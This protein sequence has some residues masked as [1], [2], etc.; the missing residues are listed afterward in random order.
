MIIDYL[1]LEYGL[2]VLN[3]YHETYGLGKSGVGAG[4]YSNGAVSL[5]MG[6]GEMGDFAS[7][8]DGCLASFAYGEI[9]DED[10]SGWGVDEGIV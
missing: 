8:G 3:A 4:Y 1:D 6:T 2:G 10:G 5:G 9:T 7:G